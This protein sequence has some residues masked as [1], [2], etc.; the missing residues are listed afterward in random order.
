MR[1]R[2]CSAVPERQP[3]T[4]HTTAVRGLKELRADVVVGVPQGPLVRR[5]ENLHARNRIVIGILGENPF[6]DTLEKTVRNKTV[7]DH[8]LVVKQF[9]SAAEASKSHILFIS[10]SERGQLADLIK[11]L[12][13]SNV[14]TVG[15]MEQFNEKGGMINFVMEGTKM[16]F[17]I[18]NQAATRAGLKISSKLLNLALP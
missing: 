3:D 2:R 12:E 4:G 16:R 9:G 13:G 11:A 6:K 14:L 5:K 7:E 17:R 1:I 15:E 10:T 18:N 8:P